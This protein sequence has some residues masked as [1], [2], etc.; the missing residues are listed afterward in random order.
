MDMDAPPDDIIPPGMVVPP[1][2]DDVP[3]I[4]ME[5]PLL[6]HFVLQHDFRER[7]LVAIT[8]AIVALDAGDVDRAS[9]IL[10]L[11]VDPDDIRVW[12]ENNRPLPSLDDSPLGQSVEELNR[13]IGGIVGSEAGR[14][15]G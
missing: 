13:I 3:E 1:P 5:D 10:R 6:P 11:A 7:Y 2:I 14:T 9:S 4:D 12:Q 15:E 8:D